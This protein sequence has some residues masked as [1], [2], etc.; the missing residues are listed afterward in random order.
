MGV[1][2]GIQTMRKGRERRWKG[3]N[4]L[5]VGDQQM[6][7]LLL[8]EHTGWILQLDNPLGRRSGWD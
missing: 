8:G 7:L 1:G 2:V 3:V 6:L 4:G 5:T